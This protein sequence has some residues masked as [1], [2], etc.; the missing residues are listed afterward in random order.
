MRSF[1]TSTLRFSCAANMSAVL[2]FSLPCT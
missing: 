2:V 1:T